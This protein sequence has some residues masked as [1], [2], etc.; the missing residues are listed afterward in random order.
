[1]FLLALELSTSRLKVC[2]VI[3]RFALCNDKEEMNC[4]SDEDDDERNS[5]QC[6]RASSFLR[7]IN[8][9]QRRITFGRTPLDE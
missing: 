6:A 1:M 5:P 7:F 4:G 9:T 8:Q 2:R 3:V